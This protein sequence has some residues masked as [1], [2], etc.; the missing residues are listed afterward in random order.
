M[1]R[2]N[3]KITGMHLSK[4]GYV[5]I[6]QSTPRQLIE[7]NESTMRQ[8]GLKQKLLDFGWPQGQIKIIDQD[9]GKSGANSSGRDGFQTL[10]ADVS[11]GLVGAVACLECSRLSRDS[12]DW[13]RLTKFCAFT[14]TLLIDADGVYDPNNFNDSLLLGLKGTMSEAELHF[15][16]ER[17]QGGLMHK[18]KRGDLKFPIPIGYIHDGNQI[19][20]DPDIEIQKVV[21]LCF[22]VFRRRGAAN[23]VVEH[24]KINN[25]KF[26]RKAGCGFGNGEVEWITLDY[27]TALRLFHN[28][29]YA[30]AYSY[31]RSQTVWE[32]EGKK[33]KKM[34][35]DEWHVFIK[36]HHS[37]YISFEEYEKNELTLA[38]NCLATNSKREGSPPREGP[39]LLQGLVYCGKCGHSMQVNYQYRSEQR[40]PVYR[41][42]HELHN[43]FGKLCQSIQGLEIDKIISNLLIERLTPDAIEQ[44]INVRKEL[45]GRQSE[46]ITYFQLRVNKC[47]YEVELARKRYMSVDPDNRLVA[48]QLEASWNKALEELSEAEGKYAHQVEVIENIKKER[49]YALTEDLSKSFRDAFLS[50]DVSYRDK[51]RMVRYLIEDVTL[52]K[53][54]SKILIQVRFRGET[55][56]VIEINAPVN[57]FKKYTT[58]PA[59]IKYIDTAAD[60]YCDEDIAGLLN[61]NGYKTGRCAE[62]SKS[63]VRSL[64][65]LYSIP[66][67]KRRYLDK[68]YLSAK[69]KAANMGISHTF[70]CGLIQSGK[71]Q[72]DYVLVNSKNEILFPPEN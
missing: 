23:R 63:K 32:P 41:C 38:E 3:S 29:F 26:P 19:I 64:R 43:Y 49:N 61:Q 5:Y 59:I 31:G 6:R 15:L 46:T 56:Q 12:E 36:D 60:N 67:K 58:D 22:D 51:K 18:V 11:N 47:R 27:N 1:N 30:G 69:T 8:Y 9:L 2:E 50:G 28:P 34:P 39:S 35:R 72:G 65:K 53:T 48:L 25:L 66:S 33:P 14:N 71:Y 20:K 52:M 40:F 16:R 62:Y 13:I 7:N 37:P 57:S 21:D 70:L 24:F 55:T 44:A 54:E 45:D 10:V 4:I 68:G 17:M 42:G